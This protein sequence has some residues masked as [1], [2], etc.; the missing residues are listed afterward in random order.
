[1]NKRM[2]MNENDHLLLRKFYTLCILNSNL[3]I[4]SLLYLPDD[5]IL[6]EAI[7]FFEAGRPQT[8]GLRSHLGSLLP[9]DVLELLTDLVVAFR[10][11]SHDEVQED[12]RSDH[13]VEKP[14]DPEHHVLTEVQ[15]AR[16]VDDR[17]VSQG[18]SQSL[19]EV[20][21]EQADFNVL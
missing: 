7:L 8:L 2:A 15:E 14:D 9:N 3:R 1:M 13:H 16:G 20:T 5:D 6:R 17:E 12:D 11:L 4:K 18:H 21:E 10:S 19:E